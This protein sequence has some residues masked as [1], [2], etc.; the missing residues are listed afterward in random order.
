VQVSIGSLTNPGDSNAIGSASHTGSVHGTEDPGETHNC[1][2]PRTN[3]DA[4][5]SSAPTQ[6]ATSTAHV[7]PGPLRSTMSGDAHDSSARLCAQYSSD[8]VSVPVLIHLVM[9]AWP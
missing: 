7:S 1:D 2:F 5:S 9:H 6:P 4:A 8:T 3:L